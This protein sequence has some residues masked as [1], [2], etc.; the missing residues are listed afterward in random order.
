MI[1]TSRRT[2]GTGKNMVKAKL[3]LAVSRSMITSDEVV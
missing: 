3:G 1:F 2:E